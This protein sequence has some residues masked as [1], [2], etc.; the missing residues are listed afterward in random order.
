MTDLLISHCEIPVKDIDASK[1]F[2]EKLFGWNFKHFGNGYSLFNNRKGIT[3]G[4]KQID[5]IASGN[6][7]IFHVTV[8]N[9]DTYLTNVK[10]LGGDVVR[11][12]T[13][14]PV[15]GYYALIS[16]INK[17]TIGLYQHNK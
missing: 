13:V 11:G 1:D 5:N 8:D 10:E 12:K 17:N 6:T 15:M 14:I 4:L 3:I 2:Y 16:D 7:T 9:I